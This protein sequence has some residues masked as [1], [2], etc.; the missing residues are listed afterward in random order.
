VA[1]IIDLSMK[2]RQQGH[3]EQTRSVF[4]CDFVEGITSLVTGFARFFLVN[5]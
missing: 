3:S 4:I 1:I 5:L 2:D